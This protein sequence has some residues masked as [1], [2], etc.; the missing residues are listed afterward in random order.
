MWNNL[1]KTPVEVEVKEASSY[2]HMTLYRFSDKF[3]MIL[4]HYQNTKLKLRIAVSLI[5]DC[6]AV[7]T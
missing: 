3:K 2:L 1:K 4:H 7:E 5:Y 6:L